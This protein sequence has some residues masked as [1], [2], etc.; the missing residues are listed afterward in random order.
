MNI[1]NERLFTVVKPTHRLSIDLPTSLHTRLKTLGGHGSLSSITKA[2]LKALPFGEVKKI[3]RAG[4]TP[5]FTV[6]VKAK[7]KR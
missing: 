4:G 3:L 6:T 7:A 5:L 1:T 2:V